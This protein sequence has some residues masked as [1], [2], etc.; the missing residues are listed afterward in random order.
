MIK[1][2]TQ[3]AGDTVS[4][5]RVKQW[6]ARKS[7]M[8]FSP[9]LTAFYHKVDAGYGTT[10]HM[11]ADDLKVPLPKTFSLHSTRE[12]HRLRINSK[13]ATSRLY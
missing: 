11:R 10:L 8:S 6:F 13:S 4:V 12:M 3:A 5:K 1:S 9:F 2:V 7:D